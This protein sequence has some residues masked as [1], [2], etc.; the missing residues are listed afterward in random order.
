MQRASEDPV[1]LFGLR[2]AH[3]GVNAADDAEAASIAEAFSRFMGL[4]LSL[5]HI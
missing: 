1:E 3:V 4:P 2:I 5:I